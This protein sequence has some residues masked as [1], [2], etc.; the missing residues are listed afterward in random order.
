[1]TTALVS[2]FFVLGITVALFLALTWILSKAK[3]IQS[4]Q[5]S[6]EDDF[7]QE[8]LGS[9]RDIQSP[10][11]PQAAPE[12]PAPQQT[13]PAAQAPP[14]T[15]SEPQSATPRPGGQ[16]DPGPSPPSPPPITATP[17]AGQSSSGQSSLSASREEDALKALEQK[18]DVAGLLAG[19]G[20]S[21]SIPGSPVHGRLLRLRG[22]K[23]MLIAPQSA[24]PAWLDSQLR[25]ANYVCLA[26]EMGA[27]VIWRFEDFL[28]DQL[29][30]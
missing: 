26:G 5:H 24:D 13:P 16:A 3:E 9:V 11:A 7:E 27:K 28:A 30:K 1:M 15:A 20:D 25:Q 4:S 29:F 19:A 17:L 18:L 10:D 21:V 12:Q 8:L 22:E 2:I 6:S 23:T 14:Q